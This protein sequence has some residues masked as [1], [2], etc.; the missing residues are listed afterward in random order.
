MYLRQR[1]TEPWHDNPGGHISPQIS[2]GS[3]KCRAHRGMSNV[4]PLPIVMTGTPPPHFSVLRF[5]VA[6][7]GEPPLV[8]FEG[9]I[10]L[11]AIPGV[12]GIC[13]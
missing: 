6:I 7:S 9:L 10:I 3:S 11:I 2:A 1:Q 13:G 12:C 4:H 5:G 8:N